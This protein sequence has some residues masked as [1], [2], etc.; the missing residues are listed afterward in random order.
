MNFTNTLDNQNISVLRPIFGSLPRS[1]FQVHFT[2]LISLLFLSLMSWSQLFLCDNCFFV[3]LSFLILSNPASLSLLLINKVSH[4]LD[5]LHDI[6]KYIIIKWFLGRF[7]R[8]PNSIP[9]KQALCVYQCKKSPD[10]PCFS[11]YRASFFSPKRPGKSGFY[12][13][14][15]STN[16]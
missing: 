7:P 6:T 5:K 11:I 8:S 3:S 2:W 4:H 16:L 13:I 12:S 1:L 15:I 9:R 10:I 14:N